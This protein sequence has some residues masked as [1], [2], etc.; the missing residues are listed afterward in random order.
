MNKGEDIFATFA[1]IIKAIAFLAAIALMVPCALLY[2]RSH[3]ERPYRIPRFFHV[4]LTWLL[5]IKVRVTGSTSKTSPV[6]FVANHASYIDI[7]VLGSILE[8]GFVAKSEVANWPL[9]GY[10]ARVQNTV[11]IER[12]STR[13]IEQRDQLQEHFAKK[14]NLILFPEGTSSDGLSALHF[15][16]T[17]FGIVEDSAH[18]IPITIQPVSVTCTELDGFPLLREERSQYAWYGDMTL[19]PHLWNTFKRGH[20]TVEVIFHPPVVMAEGSNR[21]QLAAQCQEIVSRGIEQSLSKRA[22]L[23]TAH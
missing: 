18:G 5:G 15:K 7:P 17:L 4:F 9:F 23:G 12:R 11:F 14:Q 19:P 22:L 6:L 10:L 20:F 1:G 2:K 21:K 8:A 16:S 13:A 3:P